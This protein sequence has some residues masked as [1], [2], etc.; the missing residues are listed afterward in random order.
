MEENSPKKTGTVL[1]LPE[2]AKKAKLEIKNLIDFKDFIEE[3]FDKNTS[4]LVDSILT[5]GYFT[6]ASD[7][8]IEPEQEKTSI[9]ARI[10]GVLHDIAEIDIE[11]YK[12]ILSRIKLLSKIK[13]NITDRAQDGR[14]SVSLEEQEIEIRVSSVPTENGESLVLRILNPKWTIS[15]ES[16]GLRKDLLEIFKKEIKKPN[17]AIICAGPTGSGKTTTLYSFIK[18]LSSPKIKIITIEDPIEYHLDGISQTNVDKS[19]GYTFANGLKAI[20]RQ[21]PD[22]ILVGEIRDLETAK[23]AL[24]AALTG[25]LVLTTIHTND[26]GGSIARLEALGEK[27]ENIAPA[28]NIVI[29]QQLVRKVCPKCRQMKKISQE[30]FAKLERELKNLPQEIEAPKLLPDIK[31][32]YPSQEGCPDCGFMGYKGRTGIFEILK[33]D[34]EMEKFILDS[35]SIVGLKEKAIAKKMTNMRQDGFIKVLKGET[36][37]EEIERVTSEDF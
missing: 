33:I 28:I 8:H 34:N 14:F 24:Q 16:L 3:Y 11:L 1:I 10:D 20:V 21:D 9:R 2:I 12:K 31:I 36:T 13:L 19:K 15:M 27:P 26:A 22:V 5:G 32:A 4:E 17:G 29:G 18:K 30:D 37:V 23:I 6:E 35:P 7:I 25:H